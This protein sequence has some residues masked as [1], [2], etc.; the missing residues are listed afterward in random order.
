VNLFV[1][2]FNQKL[3]LAILFTLAGFSLLSVLSISSLNQLITASSEVD[4]LNTRQAYLFQL[5]LELSEQVGILNRTDLD[6]ESELNVFYQ[7]YEPIISS[8]G[9]A[10]L[11]D[12]SLQTLLLRWVEAR[13]GW[14]KATKVL[15]YDSN[16]GLRGE[17]KTSM[18][19]LGSGLF[20]L[21]GDRFLDV[22]AALDILIDKRDEASF[23][24][25]KSE[26]EN[27]YAL[28]REQDF[29]E[30]LG[31][32]I[33]AVS[34]P[35]DLFGTEVIDSGK[36]ETAAISY[37][38]KLLE[39]VNV[40]TQSQ[41]DMLVE[42]RS[43][44]THAG[45]VASRTIVISGV[46]IAGVVLG[47]LLVA[48]RQASNTLN[49]AVT[50]LA[51]ISDGD[52]S[53]RL[54]VNESRM[55]K[56]DQVGIAVNH[57]T[58]TLSNMLSQLITGSAKLE[59]MSTELTGTINEMVTDNDKT[60]E[61]T[62]LTAK[63]VNEICSTVNDMAQLTEEAHLQSSEASGIVQSGGSVINNALGTMNV[64]AQL[65]E[66]LSDRAIELRS[67]SSKVD[68]VTGMINSLASQTNLLALNA[69]IEA[70]RAGEAGRGF[71]VVADEVRN[72]AEK[73][74]GATSEIDIIIGEMLQQTQALMTEMSS[75][76]K[77]VSESREVG[78]SAVEVVDQ[79]KMLVNQAAERSSQLSLSI[80]KVAGTSRSV[81][82]NMVNVKDST[83]K[84]NRLAHEV[85]EL[86][87]HLAQLASEQ[88]DM[89]RHFHSS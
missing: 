67:S 83:N 18:S 2:G 26:L 33:E 29:E 87:S 8:G 82:V 36:Y 24:A 60:N 19:A 69:A 51:K 75:G 59:S 54:T 35:L 61:Q 5:K 25:V 89:T 3:L 49:Q 12:D 55:D 52:L 31:P 78:G 20:A 42:A 13:K 23:K 56:F 41:R 79:I 21:M 48:L 10:G 17:M 70:A 30:F 7:I 80:D 84:G 32:K 6:V 85:L 28:V 76:A 63:T 4:R 58:Q 86:A 40:R 68:D 88:K 16:S 45:S 9:E 27:F 1:L 43:G 38:E 34:T 15:G 74:V 11:T 72:L 47:L 73:T 62:E 14:L 65:F 71:S 53:Q 77:K 39:I 37:R 66:G 50:S 81:S 64:L 46:V 22:R 44:A 57:L